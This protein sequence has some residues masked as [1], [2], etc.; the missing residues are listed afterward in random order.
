MHRREVCGVEGSH[1]PLYLTK[2]RRR[3]CWFWWFKCANYDHFIHRPLPQRNQR[4]SRIF[5]Q[6]IN[7]LSCM[8]TLLLKQASKHQLKSPSLRKLVPHLH[9]HFILHLRVRDRRV[10][11]D[12]RCLVP[13]QP[14]ETPRSWQRVCGSENSSCVA[15]GVDDETLITKRCSLV[16]TN[17]MNINYFH[18]PMLYLYTISADRR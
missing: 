14:V 1:W 12:E 16:C 9:L 8:S 18:D 15:F 5:G 2:D 10:V 3:Y 11:D 6:A 17:S 4:R 7:Q 13:Y